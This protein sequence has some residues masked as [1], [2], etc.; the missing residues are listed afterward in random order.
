MHMYTHIHI[1]IYI[2]IRRGLAALVPRGG[3]PGRAAAAADNDNVFFPE[4]TNEERRRR[5]RKM[6]MRNLE[7]W[8]ASLTAAAGVCLV[9]LV[10][11]AKGGLVS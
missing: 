10:T 2:Y 7:T 3:R 1:Y 4:K 9:N 11:G 5:V 6:I 8:L